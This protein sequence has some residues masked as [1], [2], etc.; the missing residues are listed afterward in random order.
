MAGFKIKGL[1][2]MDEVGASSAQ[3]EI[4]G[5]NRNLLIDFGIRMRNKR[6]PDGARLNSTD[7]P[8]A[9]DAKIDA[10]LITHAHNDH[11]GELP[12][13]WP[14]ILRDN[15]DAKVIMT[16]PT[17]YIACQLWLN[18]SYLMESAKIAATKEGRKNFN[19]GMRLLVERPQ[20]IEKPA[21]TE[22]F[23]GVETLFYP[24][25][26][27]RGSAAIVLKANGKTIMF[28]GDM[29]KY[30]SPTVKGMQVPEELIG[31]LDAV[32][33]ES[34]YGD[35]VLIPRSE[36]EDRMAELAKETLNRG[37]ICLAPA[38]GVGRCPDA[39]LAQYIRG[40]APLYIDGMGKRFMDI[41]ASPEGYW[42][43]LDHFSGVDF[44]TCGI[45]YVENKNERMDLIYEGGAFSVV[46]TAGMMV[47]GSCA[48]QYATRNSFLRNPLNAVLQTGYQAENTEG[49][50]LQT[51]ARNG[52]PFWIDGRRITV[53]AQVPDQ[54]QLSSHADGLQI[55][56]MISALRPRK[57]FVIHGN[58]NGREGLKK[59]LLNLGFGGETH[60]PRNGDT[61]EI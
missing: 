16:K 3:I 19:R 14:G 39:A 50:D 7:G 29:S 48:W 24:N 37:G 42:C 20:L 34:T 45:R 35:R 5:I 21:W 51:A 57:V 43:D 49:Y 38:F 53:R 36:E 32:F 30:D 33:T 10:A 15:P 4:P 56:D 25:G 61:I 54:L 59:N 41:S 9:P 8:V 28:T 46:T 17:F 1:G 22:I 40:V 18:T 23:P 2:G 52:E 13:I 44:K 11:M 31:K 55:A 6:G 47:E 26:H 60:L 27:I 58:D 12:R